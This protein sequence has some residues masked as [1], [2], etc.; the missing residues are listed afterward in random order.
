MPKAKTV[1][2]QHPLSHVNMDV[3]DLFFNSQHT[4]AS[5]RNDVHRGYYLLEFEASEFI[6]SLSRL[7]SPS[8]LPTVEDLVADFLARL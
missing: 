4:F 8:V 2:A 3:S 5:L 1:K 6:S 7:V